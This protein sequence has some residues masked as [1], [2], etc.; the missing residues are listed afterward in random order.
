MRPAIRERELSRGPSGQ[1]SVEPAVHLRR[2]HKM[3]LDV[4]LPGSRT[5]EEKPNGIRARPSVHLEE[6]NLRMK[7][8]AVSGAISE[9]LIRIGPLGRGEQRG[10]A[11]EI[12]AFAMPLV[13]AIRKFESLSL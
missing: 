4:M 1:K 9:C 13:D 3:R 7:L 11:S 2:L 10:A 6:S 8:E 12:E 5:P